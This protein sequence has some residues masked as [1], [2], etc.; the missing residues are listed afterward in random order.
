MFLDW[1]MDISDKTTLW[2]FEGISMMSRCL[3]G[4]EMTP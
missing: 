2:L 1:V 3:G 4:G